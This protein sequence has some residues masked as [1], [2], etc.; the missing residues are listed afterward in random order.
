MIGDPGRDP[1][2]HPTIPMMPVYPQ[3]QQGS[4]YF[5]QFVDHDITFDVSS[6][7]DAE[8]DARTINNMRSPALDLDSVYGRGPGLDPFL[9]VFPSAGPITAIK[10][11]TGTNRPTGPGG[12]EQ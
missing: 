5:G 8:A 1:I 9:Y 6:T 3:C 10:L 12:P 11:L 2:L 7:L 4:T